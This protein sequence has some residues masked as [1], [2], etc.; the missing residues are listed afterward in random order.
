MTTQEIT[1]KIEE[2]KGKNVV[3]ANKAISMG[4]C[5]KKLTLLYGYSVEEYDWTVAG[6]ESQLHSDM[7]YNHLTI[8]KLFK[9]NDALIDVQ[10]RII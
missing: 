1:L 7:Q 6:E 3:L 4:L 2:L 10:S 5:K 9:L 8:E